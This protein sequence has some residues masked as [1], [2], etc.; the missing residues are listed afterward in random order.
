VVGRVL[1]ATLSTGAPLVFSA[2]RYGT[3][4]AADV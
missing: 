2:G 3:F 1:H 4:A